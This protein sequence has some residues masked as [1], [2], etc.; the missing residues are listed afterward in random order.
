MI[1]ALAAVQ[2]GGQEDPN[3]YSPLDVNDIDFDIDF[4]REEVAG[5]HVVETAQE[6]SEDESSSDSSS[7]HLSDHY[8]CPSDDN[9]YATTTSSDD[10]ESSTG[11]SMPGLRA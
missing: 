9:T 1:A 2:D 11:S 10:G 5:I 4:E 3:S 8:Y 7:Y 6:E